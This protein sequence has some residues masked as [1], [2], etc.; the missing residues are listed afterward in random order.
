MNAA[1]YSPRGPHRVLI[2]NEAYM[3]VASRIYPALMG[4]TVEQA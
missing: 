4:A 2:Y 3:A 1:Q